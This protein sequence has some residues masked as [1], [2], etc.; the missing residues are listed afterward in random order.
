MRAF[1][2]LPPI[3][4]LLFHTLLLKDVQPEESEYPRKDRVLR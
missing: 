1:S 2:F 3:T 4:H